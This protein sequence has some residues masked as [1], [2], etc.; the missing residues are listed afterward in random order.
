MYRTFDYKCP[1]CGFD[2]EIFSKNHEEIKPCPKC[3]TAMDK[4]LSM[5]TFILKGVGCHS[6]GTYS[7]AKSGPKLDKELLQLDDVSL[8]RELG[9]PDDC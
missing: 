4:Q 7:N 1:S 2:M 8:N 9:L 3:H 5:P 6:N